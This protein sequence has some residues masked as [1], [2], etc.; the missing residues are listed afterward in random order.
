[1]RETIENFNTQFAFKPE[2]I[3]GGRLGKFSKFIVAGMGGSHLAAD[4]IKTWKPDFDVAVHSDYGPLALADSQAKD[5]LV[6]LSSY[7]GNT[8]ETLD[9]LKD[10]LS[11]GLPVAAISVGG[12]LLEAAKIRGIPY[13]QIPDIGIQPR[14]ATGFSFKALLKLM[15]EDEALQ[16]VSGLADSLVPLDYEAEGKALAERLAGFVPL[17]YAS[18]RNRAI[19]QNWK[20]KF[21]ETGKIPAFYNVLP[22]LNHNE[23]TGFDVKEPTEML[24]KNF[25]FIILKDEDDQPRILKRMDVLADLLESRN[26]PVE[27]LSSGTGDI[28][29]KIFSALVMADWTAFYTAEG[30]GLE[31]EEVPMVEEFKKLI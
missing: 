2:I 26:F 22:E 6:I 7:S 10:A 25:Y 1:M 30:Y 29:E 9:A 28:F 17:I 12:K 11:R 8:E 27:V 4:L 18:S 20:I 24:S 23:M 3:N 21:N 13:V 16:K 19:A 14:M 31:S 5:T 15:G